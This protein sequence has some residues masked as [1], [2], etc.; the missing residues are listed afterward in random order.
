MDSAETPET[1]NAAVLNISNRAKSRYSGGI[2][3]RRTPGDTVLS[4]INIHLLT[5]TKTNKCSSLSYPPGMNGSKPEPIIAY[6]PP[7]F[8][9][10]LTNDQNKV[11]QGFFFF[12]F[13]LSSTAVGPKFFN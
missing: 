9:S 5:A 4:P 10:L 3:S 12:Y 1:V 2:L 8:S 11:F 13:M 7:D 6:Y